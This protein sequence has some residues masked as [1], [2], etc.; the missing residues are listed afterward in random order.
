LSIVFDVTVEPG[1]TPANVPQP[2]GSA[3]PVKLI[4]AL[5]V[6]PTIG[7]LPP[8]RSTV[9]VSVFENETMIVPSITGWLHAAPPT[10]SAGVCA[11][12]ALGSRS[13]T[14]GFTYSFFRVRAPAA[15]KPP[16]TPAFFKNSLRFSIS[17]APS[18]LQV[19][20]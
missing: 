5:K 20:Q 1:S 3:T 11:Y 6:E 4:D 7:A 2:P 13:L 17:A 14:T 16:A 19:K 9:I 18:L 12:A 8:G 15:P 10:L